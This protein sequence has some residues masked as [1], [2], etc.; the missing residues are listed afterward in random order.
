MYK[1]TETT[2]ATVILG[3]STLSGSNPQI[4]TPKRYDE[5]PRYFNRKVPLWAY[6]AKHTRLTSCATRTIIFQR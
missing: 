6:D 1:G 4:Q 5:H 3:F 2:L